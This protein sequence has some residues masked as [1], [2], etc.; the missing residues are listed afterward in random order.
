MVEALPYITRYAGKTIVVK[1]GGNAMLN[2]ELKAAVTQDIVLMRTVGFCPVLVHGGGPEIT[3]LMLRLGKQPEFIGGRRVTD[4]ETVEIAEMV[5]V[6]KVNTSIVSLL[7]R[8]GGKAVGLSGKDAQLIRAARRDAGGVD[9]GF[10]GDVQQIN[11]ELL[12]SL[13]ESG[14]IPVVSSVGEG[15]DGASYNINADNVAGEIAAEVKA[16]KLIILTDVA[17]VLADPKD[18]GSLLGEINVEQARNLIATGA[19]DR[20]MIPKIEACI[21]AVEAGVERAHIIDGR[22]P[23]A[24]LMEVLTDHGVGTMV[25]AG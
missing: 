19:A 16:T 25:S 12:M 14:Y 15:D 22:V 17:G 11:P 7:N 8:Q 9:L 6:G 23:H 18:P 21:R 13:A 5:L 2:E 1:Y 4:Q 20:G 10:V 24:V 3:D